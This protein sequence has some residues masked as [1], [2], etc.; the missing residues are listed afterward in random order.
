MPQFFEG[1]LEATGLKFGIVVSRFNSF[2]CERLLEGAV[3]ALI[4]HGVDDKNNNKQAAG[5]C[6]QHNISKFHTE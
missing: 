5:G 3:D 2:I 1:K 4:R 6:K